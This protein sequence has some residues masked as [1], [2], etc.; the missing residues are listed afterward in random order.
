MLA[1]VALEQLDG[2]IAEFLRVVLDLVGK[3]VELIKERHLP[4]IIKI[5]SAVALIF[6]AC[7]SAR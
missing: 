2:A 7:P 3:L 4:T 1:R 5:S 6:Q